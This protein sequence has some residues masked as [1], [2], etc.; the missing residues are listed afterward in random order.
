MGA[1]NYDP[2][3][4]TFTQ[5]DTVSGSASMPASMNQFTYAA[6]SPLVYTDATG[7]MFAAQRG[8]EDPPHTHGSSSS[9]GSSGSTSSSN[10]PSSTSVA[11]IG[12]MA[13]TVFRTVASVGL[14]AACLGQCD[15]ATAYAAGGVE[16][17]GEPLWQSELERND[18]Y[19]NEE[20]V[21]QA[22][23]QYSKAQAETA[24]EQV[25]G[26]E[27]RQEEFDRTLHPAVDPEQRGAPATSSEPSV[28][29]D[30]ST[31]RGNSAR[32]T[33]VGRGEV[34]A[35]TGGTNDPAG[36][37]RMTNPGARPS[38]EL[39]NRRT[40]Y[41]AAGPNETNDIEGSG[42]YN[43]SPQGS[44]GK[45]FFGTQAEA[46]QYGQAA[47]DNLENAVYESITSGELSN[48]LADGLD[49]YSLPGVERGTAYYVPNELLGEFK[50]VSIIGRLE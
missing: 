12:H 28:E 27:V 18:A 19:I 15:P 36:A 9:G 10:G 4:A 33:D 23:S 50:N 26:Q 22:P 2:T 34:P 7:N 16:A 1:R 25:R 14:Q 8:G 49:S 45:S 39:T 47:N 37:D 48:E 35:E 46:E 42:R 20:R 3:T 31:A 17:E 29:A 13:V 5:R 44:E 30:G 24:E 32:P 40:F 38:T 21:G 43:P 11:Q 6:D 41:R